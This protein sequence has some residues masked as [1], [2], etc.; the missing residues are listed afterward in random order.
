MGLRRAGVALFAVVLLVALLPLISYG[1]SAEQ[2]AQEQDQ[3]YRLLADARADRAEIEARLLAALEEY[4]RLSAE[5]AAKSASVARL[6]ELAGST[7]AE[8]VRVN[9]QIDQKAVDAYMDGL[10]SP[11]GL[12]F[13]S[14]SFQHALMRQPIIELL[15]GDHGDTALRLTVN[16]QSFELLRARIASETAEVAA[17][18]I[19]AEAAADHLEQLFG[20]ADQRVALA[21]A[22][23]RAADRAYL[24]ALDQIEQAQAE[25]AAQDREDERQ[26]TTTSA[27]AASTTTLPPPPSI[28]DRP[29]KPAVERW[30][31][32][33]VVYFPTEW[34]EAALRIMQ[35]ESL[36]DPAAYNPY[37]GASGLFQF[38][39]GTWAVIAPKAGFEGSS[40]FDPEANI[41][42][43]AWL[44]KY[45]QSLGRSPWT[46]WYCTP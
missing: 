26:A 28:G 1:Q 2:A 21:I 42:T 6:G 10:T 22:D 43:A 34:V 40:P 32:I 19:Q 8:L 30:R 33:V 5:V 14:D 27:P 16:R 13:Q 31:P 46:P 45:Y 4:Q 39:P 7:R 37:S 20:D 24:A 3:A 12:V 41:A 36:G 35:C 15:I 29:L 18:Q 23:A 38:L 9:E 44:A 11:V 17:L 25:A